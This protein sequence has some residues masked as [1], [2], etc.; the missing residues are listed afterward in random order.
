MKILF[1]L[2]DVNFRRLKRDQKDLIDRYY[3]CFSTHHS[4]S[5]WSTFQR[6]FSCPPEIRDM[7]NIVLLWNNKNKRS[8]SDLSTRLGIDADDLQYIFKNICNEKYD[9][10]VIDST[11]PDKFLRKNLF[12]VINYGKN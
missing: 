8:L 3:G 5:V 9:F 1:I 10:L 12:K 4:I 7:S 11:R 6:A 2:E